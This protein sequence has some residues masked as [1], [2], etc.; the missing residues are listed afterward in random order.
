MCLLSLEICF[1]IFSVW[2]N[3]SA[4][5][6]TVLFKAKLY[7][8][9]SRKYIGM[10]ILS[11]VHHITFNCIGRNFGLFRWKYTQFW[12]CITPVVYNLKRLSLTTG[13]SYINC[14][15]IELFASS[16]LDILLQITKIFNQNYYKM[17][18]TP[19]GTIN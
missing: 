17:N 1:H 2:W 11:I 7:F 16:S 10:S 6:C 15:R 13:R 5:K 19:D 4:C 14:E 9:R 8:Q 3:V 18:L 12:Q